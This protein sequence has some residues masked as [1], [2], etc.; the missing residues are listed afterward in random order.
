MMIMWPTIDQH[1]RASTSGDVRLGL[2]RHATTCTMPIQEVLLCQ[3][4]EDGRYA[5]HFRV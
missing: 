5:K 1:G 2:A 3:S 4:F